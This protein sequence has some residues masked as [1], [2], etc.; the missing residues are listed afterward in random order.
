MMKRKKRFTLIIDRFGL[1]HL[2][3]TQTG[4]MF[5]FA[6]EYK[7]FLAQNEFSPDINKDSLSDFLAYNCIMGDKTWFKNVNLLPPAS[8][9]S[10]DLNTKKINLESYWDWKSVVPLSS[11]FNIKEFALEWKEALDDACKRRV[12][13]GENLGIFLSG[14]LD[15]RAITAAYPNSANPLQAVT[16]GRKG[17]LDIKVATEIARKKNIKHHIFELDPTDWIL[18][19]LK[20]VWWTEGE[21][22]FLDLHGI[23]SLEKISSLFKISFNG[24]GGG[25]HS[26]YLINYGMGQ[27]SHNL[28]NPFGDYGRRTAARGVTL[29]EPYVYHRTPLYDNKL[30]ELTLQAPLSMLASGKLYRNVL[31][32]SYNEFYQSIRYTQ[33]GVPI[34]VPSPLYELIGFTKRVRNKLISIGNSYGLNSQMSADYIDYQSWFKEPLSHKFFEKVITQK[35]ALISQ[36]Y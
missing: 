18:S 33:F 23:E 32:Q 36:F 14:G 9:L 15:S 1:R 22:T 11:N 26:G 16:F 27:R 34:G 29:D 13:E 30:V 17:C 20:G 8:T 12:K 5:A 31:L 3:W 10:I 4:G 2:F 24:L 7:S 25:F 21:L 6:Q 28:N 19:R 35:S